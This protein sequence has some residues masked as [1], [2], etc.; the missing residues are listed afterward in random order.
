MVIDAPLVVP[1]TTGGST[2]RVLFG[3][4]AK[5]GTQEVIKGD[6]NN[7]GTRSKGRTRSKVSTSTGNVET[8][9]RN[10]RNSE[11]CDSLRKIK[12]I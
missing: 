11:Y 6:R 12:N 5:K 1:G 9:R 4:D 3:E 2:Q 10:I 7:S 8:K